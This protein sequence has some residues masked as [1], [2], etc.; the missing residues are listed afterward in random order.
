LEDGGKMA[1]KKTREATAE[2]G[3]RRFI[4]GIIEVFMG[5]FQFTYAILKNIIGAIEKNG[6]H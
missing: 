5:I 4:N 2:E 6:K 1:K 3:F